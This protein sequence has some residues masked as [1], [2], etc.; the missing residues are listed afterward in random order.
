MSTVSYPHGQP[1]LALMEE[2]VSN[3]HYDFLEDELLE[4]LFHQYD[5]D[6]DGDSDS[7]DDEDNEN[8]GYAY[9]HLII[10]LF[11]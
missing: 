10:F 7:S 3:S 11:W 4:I 9:L 2:L 8:K 5:G 1:P 6:Y